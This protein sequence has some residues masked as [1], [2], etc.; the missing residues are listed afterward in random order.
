MDFQLTQQTIIKFANQV[1]GQQIIQTADEF[2]TQLSPFDRSARLHVSGPVDQETFLAFLKMHVLEWSQ[3]DLEKL[4]R[5]M[6]LMQADIS[7]FHLPLPAEIWLVKTTGEEEGGGTYTRGN[8]VL[9]PQHRLDRDLINLKELLIHE[10]FHILSRYNPNIRDQLY[11]IIGFRPCGEIELPPAYRQRLITNPDSP[12]NQHAIQIQ[13]TGQ[14][15]QVIP[16]LYAEPAIYDE[17]TQKAHFEYLAARWM[18]IEYING[19][20]HSTIKNNDLILLE[21]EE[22]EGFY[23]QIGRNTSYI[24]Q[25]EEIMACNFTDMVTQKN[26]LANPEIPARILAVLQRFSISSGG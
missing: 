5:V 14:T 13:F 25:P 7:L 23:E 19:K 20:W 1:K 18:V 11:A 6:A 4:N 2:I 10:F 17:S 24:V 21:P 9:L 16:I 12:K 22:M 8:A 3:D 26:D 15:C